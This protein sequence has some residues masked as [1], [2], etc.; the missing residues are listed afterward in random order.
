MIS[1]LNSV[2][3]FHLTYPLNPF[4]HHYSDAPISLVN[5]LTGA[6]MNVSTGLYC[7]GEYIMVCIA[8]VSTAH[9][10]S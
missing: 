7:L 8:L 6:K 10:S 9:R 3:L 4:V 1:S 5:K 2:F